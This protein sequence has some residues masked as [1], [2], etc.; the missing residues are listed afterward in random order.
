MNTDDNLG[1]DRSNIEW[2]LY[3]DRIKT[4]PEAKSEPAP[5]KIPTNE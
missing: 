2:L 1:K 4:E 3:N 5:G